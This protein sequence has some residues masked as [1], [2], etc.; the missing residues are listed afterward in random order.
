MAGLYTGTGTLF[1]LSFFSFLSGTVR[2]SLKGQRF[3]YPFIG[4]KHRYGALTLPSRGCFAQSQL[5]FLFQ[6]YFIQTMLMS[7]TLTFRPWCSFNS[8][9]SLYL[10]SAFASLAG[11]VFG[12]T[13]SPSFFARS[14]T[15]VLISF[16]ASF[17]P[18]L[19]SFTLA[20]ISFNSSFMLSSS[21]F[22]LLRRSL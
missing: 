22:H 13:K 1:N 21:F 9:I 17:T 15:S 3:I 6:D 2:R 20:P 5:C 11:I 4:C 14:F 8:C 16:T 18:V 19:I 7:C 10:P 12:T